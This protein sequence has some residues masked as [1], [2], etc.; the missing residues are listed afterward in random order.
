MCTP[1]GREDGVSINRRIAGLC[2]LRARSPGCGILLAM[3]FTWQQALPLNPPCQAQ[4]APATTQEPTSPQTDLTQLSIENLMNVEVTSV[5]K[6][7]Q[8]LSRVAS[9]VFVITAEDIRRSGAGNIP[10]LLRMV[11]GLQVAQISSSTWAITARG[12]DGQYSNKLLVLVDGRTVY[13]PIFSGTFWDAL[14]P[15]LDD[16]ERIE[17]IRGPG[18]TVWG[19]NAVNGVINITTKKASDTKGGLLTGGGGTSEAGFGTAQY[20]GEIGKAASYRVYSGGFNQGHS[21]NLA[22]QD[23]GD[24]WHDVQEGF[25]VDAKASQKD[26]L[27]IEGDAYDGNAGEQV[28]SIISI[29]PP[30]NGILSLRDHFSGW[31]VVSRWDH[32]A[33]AHAETS[34]QVN[35]DHSDRGDGTYGTGLTT[36]GIEFVN[37]IGW[38]ERHDIVWGLGYGLTSDKLATTFRIAFTPADQTRQLFSSFVQDE[39]TLLPDRLYLTAGVKLEHNDFTGF[40]FEPSVRVAWSASERTMFWVAVSRAL[41]TPSQS[42]WDIRVNESVFPGPNNIP[43]VV[44]ILGSPTRLDEHLNAF[45]AGYRTEITKRISLDGTAFF[46]HYDNLVSVE[47]G[48]PFLE[49]VPGPLHLV[50]PNDL[51]NSLYG[52]THGLELSLN[53]KVTKRWTL[54]SGYSFLTMHLH[55]DATSQDT[56][57]IQ[58][59]Q[60]GFPSHQAQLRSHVDLGEHWQWNAAAY[61]VGRLPAPAVPSYTRLD[62]NVVWQPSPRFSISLVGQNLLKDHHL[63]YVGPDQTE[64]SSLIKRSVYAKFTWQF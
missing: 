21:P 59:T 22:G 48:T 49:T 11:P 61:F 8:K 34:L 13:S 32:I 19:A 16:I 27:T 64:Q 42:D 1:L 25:R 31:D 10:D 45:E 51:A 7:E 52:E 62:T 26:T 4:Q 24:D 30:T 29:S 44:S 41:R 17:V 2:L 33:S 18:A 35:F 12:F 36:L 9:A 53:T 47:P 23:G 57:T 63:E 5:S 43:V 39:I 58:G 40:G 54:S 3:L 20:G 37:H 6:K 55:E 60:G 50:V 15:P 46:N 38:G 14:R 28:A 56:T